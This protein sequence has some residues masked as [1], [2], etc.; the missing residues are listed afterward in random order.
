MRERILIVEDEPAISEA[1]EYALRAEGFEVEAVDDGNT[2]LAQA[3]AR[4]YDLLVL[5]LMLPGLSGVEVCRQLRDENP[6]PILMLTAKD[7]EV[8]RVLG[9]EVGADDYVTKPFSVPELVARVR[10][11]L[12]R[13]ELDTR[14]AIAK[15]RVGGLELDLA[16]HQARLNGEQIPLTAFELKLLTLLAGEPERVF[17]RGEIMRHLW[18]SSYVGDERA[19]DLHVSNIRRKIER[20]PARPERLVTVRGSGYKLQAV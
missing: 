7:A 18:D 16:K 15:L 17:S 11:L 13:R 4:A 5:D 8:D 10:A 14:Q 9:L 20:D 2:A 3:R 1:V 19:C 12:R 6:V